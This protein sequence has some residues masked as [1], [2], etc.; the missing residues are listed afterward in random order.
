M[1]W[2]LDNAEGR[3]H[4]SGLK[5]PNAWG[6]YDMH[7]NIRQWCYDWFGPYPG[8]E[9]YDPVESSGLL[10]KNRSL[11][12]TDSHGFVGPINH[13]SRGGCWGGRA[14]DCRSAARTWCEP[15]KGYYD[16][17]FRLA[18]APRLGSPP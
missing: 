5:Q 1:G 8:G 16:Q 18:L 10:I 12:Q 11:L 17:G 4:S 13:V 9:V 2:Y 6:L 3:T 7:G 15:F 14:I